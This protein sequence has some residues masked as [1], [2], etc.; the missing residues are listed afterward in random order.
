MNPSRVSKLVFLSS[1]AV[2]ALAAGAAGA[3]TRPPAGS[4]EIEEIVVTALRREQKLQDV[5]AAISVLDA[6]A[7]QAKGAQ[8][9]RDY[10]TTVPGVNFSEG[11]LR[12]MRVT[13]RGVADGS[14]AGDPLTGI[15]I[16]E[17][18]V[19][20]TF[21]STLDPNIY[22]VERVEVLK[23]PQGTLYGSGSMG[24]TVR[25]ITRKPQLD[26]FAAS[27]EGTVSTIAHGG[28]NGRVDAMVNLPVLQDK[29]ALRVSAG[30]RKDA[31]WV[32]N[33]ATHR[34]DANTVEKKSARAQLL[35][36]PGEDTSLVLGV[37]YQKEDL[38]AP[39]YEDFGLAQYQT[40]R[41]FGETGGSDAKLFSATLQHDYDWLSVTSAT[42]Y[43][44]KNSVATSDNTVSLRSLV[45]RLAGVTAGA[46]EGF[47]VRSSNDLD[48]FTQELRLASK[49]KNRVDWV[50]GGFYSNAVTDASTVF[51]FSQA[52]S[53]TGKTTG[54]AFYSADQEYRTR[55]VAAFGELTF[56][57][58]DKLALTG[59]LRVFDV[60]QR[61]TLVGSGLLNGGAT[62]TQQKASNSSSTKKVLLSYQATGA[63]LVYAQAAQ[64]Y[65]NGGP[66]GGFP[67]AACAADLAAVGLSS[68]PNAYG[69]DKLWNYEL[70]SKNT[71]LGGRMTLNGAAYYIDWSNMQTAISLSCGFGLTVNAGKAVS[72]GAELES[73]LKPIKGLTLAGSVSYVDASLKETVAKAPGHAGD[74][75]PFTAKWSWNLSAQYDRDLQNGLVGFVRGEVNH[76][77]DRWSTFQSVTARARLLQ[78]YTTLNARVGVSRDNWSLALF[79]SN[80]TDEHIVTATPGTSYQIVGT[81]RVIGANLKVNY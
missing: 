78:A 25:V 44:T 46:T 23:G 34:D 41:I 5:P 33:I 24:G 80:L 12:S 49:G 50:A 19:T 16:D 31:G 59:G 3:Q 27:A 11:G 71:L 47:G 58:T 1:V 67:Q 68:V 48:L 10:L 56:N 75:L 42:N 54:A 72:K 53:T 70:G 64:G 74:R 17:T 76:V 8:D 39:F 15:Y 21:T 38:G 73:T 29:I 79:G 26:S 77:G 9:Y 6:A 7:I 63:N 62:T 66:T 65:R 22:D 81:P 14:S 13:I 40:G 2:A 18:P 30:Y 28:T 61:N 32:D 43:V 60:D 55:Q 69:P 36:K 20:E 4:S 37:L 35:L 45:Q 51:D 52:P 57:V